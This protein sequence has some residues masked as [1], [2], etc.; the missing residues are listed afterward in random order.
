[1]TSSEAIV[2][3]TFESQKIEGRAPFALHCAFEGV[4]MDKRENSTE[5]RNDL[6]LVRESVE[7]R[8]VV[9]ALPD[10]SIE[11]LKNAA[12][13]GSIKEVNVASCL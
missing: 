3:K 13:L 10:E 8:L 7:V 5:R 4:D 11:K 1:M 9:A 6:E 2:F 12:G